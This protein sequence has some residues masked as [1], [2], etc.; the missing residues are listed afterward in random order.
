MIMLTRSLATIGFFFLYFASYAQLN[1][2]G[3]PLGYPLDAAE[4]N[5][6]SNGQDTISLVELNLS[7]LATEDEEDLA[8]N[9]PPRFGSPSNVNLNL[10]NSG[11]W[12]VLDNGDR[13]WHLVIKGT[14]ALSINLLY[15]KFWLPEKSK[16]FIYNTELT[17]ILGAFTSLNNKG[18]SETVGKFAT[19]LILDNEIVLE[20]YEPIE[21][22][23]EGILEIE[24]INQGYR[25]INLQDLDFGD[26]GDCQ[27]NVNCSPEGDAWRT[28]KNSVALI[29]INGIRW[30]TGSLLNNALL[31]G[32]PYFLSADHC[33]NELVLDDPIDA[34]DSPDGSYLQFYWNYESDSCSNGIDFIPPST[35]G[36]TLIA[37]NSSSD[38]ALFRLIENPLDLNPQ[39]QLFFN[40]WDRGLP[41]RGGVGIHHPRGDIKKI[42]THDTIPGSAA[43]ISDDGENYWSLFWIETLNGHSVTE[44]GSSGSPLYNNNHRVIGQLFG[45][46]SINCAN[47]SLDRALYGKIDV[48]WDNSSIPQ[49]RLKDWLDPNS[50]DT[51]FLNG[52]R[53]YT[54]NI[55]DKFFGG[56]IE[57]SNCYFN[58]KGVKMLTGK[59]LKLEATYAISIE[60]DFEICKTCGLDLKIK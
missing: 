45:G 57:Y 23:G 46:G 21:V 12:T 32:T 37:N 17:Q 31:N 18:K 4:N 3:Q 5:V 2:G 33:F 29:I 48:S 27:V 50:L 49:R 26:S 13:V 15:N 10:I 38:F 14:S 52:F 47:P 54:Q 11:T 1:V 7:E 40:G 20:Y 25:H 41:E 58:V 9:N 6:F 28:E 42:S 36:A 55:F 44:R 24:W 59:T 35:T 39:P 56:D 16:F 43:I 8:N 22:V 34:I 51:P 53:C 60:G 30:C 19:G